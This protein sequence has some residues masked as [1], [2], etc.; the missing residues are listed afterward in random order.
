MGVRACLCPLIGEIGI[1]AQRSFVEP[2]H[3]LGYLGP[4]AVLRR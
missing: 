3:Q 4:H 1:E 2:I